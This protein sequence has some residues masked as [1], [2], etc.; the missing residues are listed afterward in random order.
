[1]HGHA[2]NKNVE[3][4]ERI[5]LEH[6]NNNST[7]RIRKERQRTVEIYYRVTKTLVRYCALNSILSIGLT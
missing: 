1:M 2:A 6:L 5:S 3:G 4:H 7:F